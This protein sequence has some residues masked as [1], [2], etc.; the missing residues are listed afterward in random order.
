MA[1]KHELRAIKKWNKKQ[2]IQLP[3]YIKTVWHWEKYCIISWGKDEYKRHCL[4]LELH[5]GGFSPNEEIVKVL[6]E[7]F[8]WSMFWQ[9]SKRGG[10]YYFSIPLEALGYRDVRTVAKEKKVTKQAI[11][12]RI[13]R[14]YDYI[15]YNDHK[16][17]IKEKI[18]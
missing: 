14:D 18:R 5:T 7:T 3:W 17:F 12:K 2:Y 11:N 8:F 16:L 6:Q 4:L 9:V 10:H 1:Y 15:K 13:K